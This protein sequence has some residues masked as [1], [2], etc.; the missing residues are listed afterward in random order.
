MVIVLQVYSPCLKMYVL[1]Q[2]VFKVPNVSQTIPG[3]L[4]MFIYAVKWWFFFHIFLF[5]V[6]LKSSSLFDISLPAVVIL[7]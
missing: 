4:N 6:L 1:E 2:E 7:T 5:V 3:K